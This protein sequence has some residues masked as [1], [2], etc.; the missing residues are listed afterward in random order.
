MAAIG[1]LR[2]VRWVHGADILGRDILPFDF[3]DLSALGQCRCR[4]RR[5]ILLPGGFS[6]RPLLGD[7][8]FA[9]SRPHS[10]CCWWDD[11][12]KG[13]AEEA[14]L[15]WY[16]Q[17]ARAQSRSRT[18]RGGTPSSFWRGPWEPLQDRSLAADSPK[19]PRFDGS[20]G[21]TCRSARLDSRPCPLRLKSLLS[22]PFDTQRLVQVDWI[23][24]GLFVMSATGLLLG[25]SWA[26]IQF[27]WLSWQTLLPLVGGSSGL[28]FLC[29]WEGNFAQQPL[30]P[31]CLFRTTSMRAI[32]VATL[33]QGL[34]VSQLSSIYPQV[35]ADLCVAVVRLVLLTPLFCSCSAPESPTCCCFHT[36]HILLHASGLCSHVACVEQDW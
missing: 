19:W 23:G 32:Y 24:A 30:F 33:M 10:R 16:R 1:S 27:P 17:F 29:I 36:T 4:D 34:I 9:R 18:V 3:G 21:S 5:C 31:T 13:L 28:L 25:V 12:C 22:G 15:S 11:L 14:L 7:L 2:T 6:M 35:R 8:R 26:G 20:S